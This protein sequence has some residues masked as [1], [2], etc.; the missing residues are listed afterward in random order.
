MPG[1]CPEV[2]SSSH[3]FLVLGDRCELPHF[4]DSN[5]RLTE[6]D[7][8]PQPLP[9]D[10]LQ[11]SQLPAWVTLGVSWGLELGDMAQASLLL[12]RVACELGK[13]TCMRSSL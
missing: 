6:K 13:G 4:G 10:T 11:S 5:M 2:T 3:L 9:R 7:N 8:F 12:L 1:Q